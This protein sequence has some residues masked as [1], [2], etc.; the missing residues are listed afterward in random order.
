MRL[1]PG[2]LQ[3]QLLPGHKYFDLSARIG[4]VTAHW[5]PGKELPESRGA[6]DKSTSV[7]RKSISLKL[8]APFARGLVGWEVL[9]GAP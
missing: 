8:I 2:A 3:A 1:I 9:G 5:V 6:F 4:C 7:W